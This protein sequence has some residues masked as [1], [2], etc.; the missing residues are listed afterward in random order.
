MIFARVIK[1]H[2]TALKESKVAQEYHVAVMNK[3]TGIVG[4][5]STKFPA[6][7]DGPSLWSTIKSLGN[8]IAYSDSNIPSIVAKV[9]SSKQNT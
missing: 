3:V 7:F 8:F 9:I 1:N 6:A 2:L 5:K 4:L